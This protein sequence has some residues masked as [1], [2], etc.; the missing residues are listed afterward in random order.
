MEGFSLDVFRYSLFVFSF[1]LAIRFRFS[2]CHC[3]LERKYCRQRLLFAVNCRTPAL[4]E[5]RKS[6]SF[7]VFSAVYTAVFHFFW[8][9]RRNL[10]A[11][12]NPYCSPFPSSVNRHTSSS[13]RCHRWRR[14]LVL[15]HDD[16]S[17]PQNQ[18]RLW[19]FTVSIVSHRLL[20]T[21]T[22]YRLLFADSLTPFTF[23][24]SPTVP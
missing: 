22:V 18:Y 16:E 11:F 3:S 12:S 24:L 15:V 14:K 10:I 23:S 13:S 1:P 6:L 20:F 2:F 8:K 7:L 19:T 9:T 21:V 5:Q 4:T 17:S